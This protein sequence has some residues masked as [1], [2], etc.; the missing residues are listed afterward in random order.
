MLQKLHL[1]NLF[2]KGQKPQQI[3]LEIKELIKSFHQVKQK[4]NKKKKE[5]NE[6]QE[7]YIPPEKYQ[8]IIDV[9][10]LFQI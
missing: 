4:I 8:Q 9:L 1:N 2:K 3:R 10:R 5:T 6:M 7:I